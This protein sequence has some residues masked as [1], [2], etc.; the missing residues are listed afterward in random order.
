MYVIIW[1]YRVKPGRAADFEEIYGESGQWVELFQKGKGYL[2]TELLH[3]SRDPDHYLTIDRWV[4]LTDYESFVSNWRK[5]YQDLDAQC[6]D[7]TGQESPLGNWQ[8]ISS[9]TR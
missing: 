7:L 3:D 2:G 8:S 6:E 5:E 1:E 9:K 4:S